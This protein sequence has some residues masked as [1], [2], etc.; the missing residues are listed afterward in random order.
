[1]APGENTMPVGVPELTLG[2]SAIHWIG[3]YLKH[4]NGPRV[5]RPFRVTDSQALFLLW[6]YAI[7]PEGRWM[8]DRGARRWPKGSGK[9]RSPL[10]TL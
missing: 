10:L 2:W 8:Y 7:T 9:A 5:G 1:M 6:F 3:K 4:A